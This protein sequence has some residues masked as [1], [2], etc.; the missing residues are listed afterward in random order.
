MTEQEIIQ[1]HKELYDYLMGIHEKDAAF[2]FRVRRMNNQNRLDK[3]YWFNGNNDYLETSFWDYKDNL[4]Q[5]S[6]IRLVYYFETKKWACE[7]IGRDS[8]AR[9]VYFENMAKQLGG[10]N[11]NER[12]AIWYKELDSKKGFTATLNDFIFSG[13]K[14]AIDKYVS[15]NVEEK[16]VRL[17]SENDFK[18]DIKKIESKKSEKGDSKT[19][20]HPTFIKNK[21]PYAL[22]YLE[23]NNFQGISQT[24]EIGTDAD[25][26]MSIADASWVFLTG[27]NGI[28]KTS[29]L[30]AIAIG[31]TKDEDKYLKEGT[32]YE[33]F[34]VAFQNTEEKYEYDFTTTE[35]EETN[36]F[37]I[38]AYGVSRFNYNKSDSFSNKVS[39]TASLFGYEG[40]LIDIESILINAFR[41]QANEVEAGVSK[42]KTLFKK[43]EKIIIAVI[44]N[45]TKIE[46][47]YQPTAPL[48]ERYYILYHE[49]ETDSLIEDNKTY[50]PVK[51]NDLATGYRNILTMVGDIV[52]R[53]S[54]NMK[55]TLDDIC[56]IVIID[57]IDAYLHPKYQYEL[58][59]LLSEAFPKV[60]FIVSTHSPIPLL[61]LPKD[62]NAVVF[63]VNRTALEGITVDRLDDD[64]DIRR[65]NPNALLTSPIF[66]FED[67]FARDA[68]AEDITP[69]DDYKEWEEIWQGLEK[70]K[71][72]DKK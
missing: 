62:V 40:R 69:I 59:K 9:K 42:D 8:E 34:I 10:F 70:L 5:T 68:K 30:K 4:H 37:K 56:G 3:G 19:V 22:K 20:V 47:K 60:Q 7:L 64:F 48:D 63:K 28:G 18:R 31:L 17:R 54:D 26:D 67:I 6:V 14:K 23:I 2:R 13:Q 66:G 52:I 35:D 29:I 11:K 49:K 57:E 16:I 43:L 38:V 32:N 61:G 1:L 72:E 24:L 53:L 51:L 58:P 41:E 27:E 33:N 12:R 71:E 65:L 46:V 36:T 50:E 55:N 45:L 21:I 15:S 39:R 44:P 25:A